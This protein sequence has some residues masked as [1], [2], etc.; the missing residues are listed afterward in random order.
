MTY[1]DQLVVN[2]LLLGLKLHLI[3]KWL[4][5]ASSAYTEMLAEWFETML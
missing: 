1:A 2:L 4:P 3:G 5:F